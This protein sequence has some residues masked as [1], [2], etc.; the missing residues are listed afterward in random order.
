MVCSWKGK[1][2]VL[3]TVAAAFMTSHPQGL[4]RQPLRLQYIAS[5]I[6]T[7]QDKELIISMQ[8]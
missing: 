7:K 2:W 5:S 1:L 4:P 8:Y 3:Q 6:T